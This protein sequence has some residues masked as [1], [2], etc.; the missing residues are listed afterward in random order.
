MFWK[1]PDF[2]MLIYVY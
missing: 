2:G 1:A